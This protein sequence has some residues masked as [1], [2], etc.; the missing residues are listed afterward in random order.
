VLETDAILLNILNSPAGEDCILDGAST[1]RLLFDAPSYI[2][3]RA[4]GEYLNVQPIAYARSSDV[5]SLVA[6]GGGASPTVLT[7]SG[8]TY[9]ARRVEKVEGSLLWSVLPLVQVA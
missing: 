2:Q 4:T 3:D 1:I 5:A 9:I 8:A 7:I 6:E